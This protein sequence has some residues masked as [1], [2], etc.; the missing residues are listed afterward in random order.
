MSGRQVPQ[1]DVVRVD[2]MFAR[3]RLSHHRWECGSDR[4]EQSTFIELL[5]AAEDPLT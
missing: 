3:L 2:R 1:D 5:S 4:D